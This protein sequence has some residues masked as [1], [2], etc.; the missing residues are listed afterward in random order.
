M[1]RKE[2]LIRNILSA[3]AAAPN[4]HPVANANPATTDAWV[5]EVTFYGLTVEIFHSRVSVSPWYDE[6]HLVLSHRANGQREE[7]F[8]ASRSL[9][10]HVFH[11][12]PLAW[13]LFGQGKQQQQ[14]QMGETIAVAMPTAFP[15]QL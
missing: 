13:V 7:F 5:A 14:Q 8:R 10:W 6:E 9:K 15:A 4:K 2:L 11:N 12:S 1:S 3:L